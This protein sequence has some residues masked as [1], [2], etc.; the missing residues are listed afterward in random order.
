MFDLAGALVL[1]I[2]DEGAVQEGM[3]A[4]LR[5]WQCE[6][7]TAGSGKEMLQQLVSVQRLPDLHHH[8][9]GDVDGE[10]DRPH[11]GLLQAALQPHTI[12]VGSLLPN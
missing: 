4:L 5:K 6:V 2:D 1:V 7:L 11:A 8:V 9:V 3:A 10:R 12:G